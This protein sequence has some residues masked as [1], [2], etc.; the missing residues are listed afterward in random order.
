MKKLIIIN[1]TFRPLDCMIEKYIIQEFKRLCTSPETYKIVRGQLLSTI[2]SNVKIKFKLEIFDE[3]IITSICSF[4]M[5]Q[6]MCKNHYKLTEYETQIVEAYENHVDILDLVKRFDCSPLNIL[7]VVFKKKYGRKLLYYVSNS[8]EH[9]KELDM[10][11][12]EQLLKAIDNDSYALISQKEIALSAENF[13]KAI[14]EFLRLQSVR[15][16][17][18]KELV[19]EQ[20][21]THS[22]PVNTPDFLILDDLIINGHKINWIDAK[23]F[24]GSCNKML[25]EKIKSQT[26]KYIKKWGSGALCFSLGFNEN[27]QFKSILV[28]DW[29]S[30]N[31]QL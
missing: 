7:R 22:K 23:Y 24:F 11:G 3:R 14:E 10:W 18:Q 6:Y 30:L 21:I 16:K 15:F 17:T 13:E 20:I 9:L 1:R 28:M 26:E 8:Y 27:L 12:K 19:D 25:I 4:Y 31:A 2:E 5:K 29:N